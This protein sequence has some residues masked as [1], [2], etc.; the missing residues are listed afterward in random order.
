MQFLLD[1]KFT[2]NLVVYFFYYSWILVI[3]YP[4]SCN[5]I[6]LQFTFCSNF[7]P[8]HVCRTC[9][10]LNQEVCPAFLPSNL[11]IPNQKT[12]ALQVSCHIP[13]FPQALMGNGRMEWEEIY[14]TNP[15]QGPYNSGRRC[16]HFSPRPPFSL[17]SL[18]FLLPTRI[19]RERA[20]Q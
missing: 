14:S 1:G 7:V 10:T 8:P 17:P 19:R 16:C 2:E 20:R 13:V 5:R 6:C 11:C 12:V 4:F 9:P 18:L 15:V 3:S